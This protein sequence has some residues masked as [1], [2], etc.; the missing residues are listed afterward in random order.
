VRIQPPFEFLS[1]CSPAYLPYALGNH[2]GCGVLYKYHGHEKAKPFHIHVGWWIE[3]RNET[4]IIKI[5]DSY[6]K[7]SYI[8]R[9]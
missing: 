4:I 3:E 6:Y 7:K 8:K 9:K 1:V 2:L 5:G